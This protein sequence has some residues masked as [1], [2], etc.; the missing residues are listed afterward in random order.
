MQRLWSGFGRM[1]GAPLPSALFRPRT[2]LLV[3]QDYDELVALEAVATEAGLGMHSKDPAAA[4]ASIRR[5]TVSEP[6]S[7][8]ENIP[9][10]P[11]PSVVLTQ[12]VRILSVS[13]VL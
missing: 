11:W 9:S 6:S 13:C 2:L 1:I 4:E 10:C 12:F 8:C 7:L 3:R 5:V